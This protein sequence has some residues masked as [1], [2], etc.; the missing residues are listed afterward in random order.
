MAKKKIKKGYGLVLVTVFLAGVYFY[1]S[2]TF[3]KTEEVVGFLEGSRIENVEISGG[4]Q[5]IV[6]KKEGGVWFVGEG[7]NKIPA[8]GEKVESFVE[9]VKVAKFDDLVSSNPEKLDLFG[10]GERFPIDWE[11]VLSPS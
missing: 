11:K 10:L 1:L 3:S 9:G 2:G 8:D 5:E 4:G 6:L 7:K